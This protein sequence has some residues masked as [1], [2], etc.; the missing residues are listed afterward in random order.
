MMWERMTRLGFRSGQHTGHTLR[1]SA[2]GA[3]IE[4]V[5]RNHR[6]AGA[7]FPGPWW[8][9]YLPGRPE[10]EPVWIGRDPGDELLAAWLLEAEQ[11][12]MR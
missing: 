11:E 9:V 4:V 1:Y 8:T 5:F 7:S 6:V 10:G 3:C 2:H 12:G